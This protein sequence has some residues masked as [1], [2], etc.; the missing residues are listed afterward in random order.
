M[1]HRMLGQAYA[2]LE[3]PREALIELAQA[4]KTHRAALAANANA[5]DTVGDLA[6]TLLTR[7]D[8]LA[9]GGDLLPALKA[10]A[11][12]VRLLDTVASRV[13]SRRYLAITH[14]RAGDAE[15]QLARASAAPA[16]NLEHTRAACRHYQQ[17]LDV[18]QSQSARSDQRAVV[19]DPGPFRQAGRLFAS[20]SH[21]WTFTVRLKA[22]TTETRSPSA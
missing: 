20:L 19:G 21:R 3:Q 8:V 11:E 7:G 1:I 5:A 18:L 6:L 13:E 4:E 2:D 22:D 14:E 16:A 15:R 17:G 12:S 9:E 10:Y